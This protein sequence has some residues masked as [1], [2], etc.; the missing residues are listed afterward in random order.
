MSDEVLHVI[1]IIFFVATPIIWFLRSAKKEL[2]EIIPENVD[3]KSY[4]DD[5]NGTIFLRSYNYETVGGQEWIV[6][7]SAISIKLNMTSTIRTIPFSKVQK[8][9][10]HKSL[11]FHE[12]ELFVLDMVQHD[13]SGNGSWGVENRLEE[14][15]QGTLSFKNSDLPIAQAVHDRIASH[16]Q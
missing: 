12:L 1:L 6:N 5:K 11:E 2:K 16:N 8:V 4:I 3:V 15:S 9:E 13:A 10:L 7:Q 14:I